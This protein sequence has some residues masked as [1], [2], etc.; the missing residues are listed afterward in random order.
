MHG[1][2]QKG[3][4]E[5]FR[6]YPRRNGRTLVEAESEYPTPSQI[7]FRIGAALLIALCVAIAASAFAG[8]MAA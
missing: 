5:M 2:T 8:A 3:I 4:G 1:R 7:A 6:S